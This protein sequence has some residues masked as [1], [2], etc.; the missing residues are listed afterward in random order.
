D[1][2]KVKAAHVMAS[3]GAEEVSR[4][5]FTGLLL[6]YQKVVEEI[7]LNEDKTPESKVET[8]T[9]LADAFNKAVAA[10]TKVLPE[11]NRLAVAMETVRTFG[12]FVR[13]KR[14]AVAM[15]FIELIEEFAPEL[16]RR[17]A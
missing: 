11:T 8:L 10:S 3:G 16:E 13:E 2:D 14:P 5:I 6:Q 17:F 12:D 4:A 1:W 9:K 7:N 15:D